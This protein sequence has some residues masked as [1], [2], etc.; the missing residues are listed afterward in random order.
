MFIHGISTFSEQLY[1]RKL[2][3]KSRRGHKLLCLMAWLSLNSRGEGQ[4]RKNIKTHTSQQWAWVPALL[5]LGRELPPLEKVSRWITMLWS[6]IAM[7]RES[8]GKHY[9]QWRC[10]N[11]KLNGETI[12]NQYSMCLQFF[13]SFRALVAIINQWKQTWKGAKNKSMQ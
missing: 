6:V 7:N 13:L 4:A 2:K 5:Y 3:V 12:P 10:H 11:R 8:Q 9:C 1:F